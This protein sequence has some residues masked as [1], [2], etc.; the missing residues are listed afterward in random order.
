MKTSIKNLFA[1]VLGLVV[2]SSSAFA[3]ESGKNN[4]NNN[5]KEKSFTILNEVK[6]INK[7]VASGNVEVFV[8]QAPAES[9]KVYDSYYSKN[10][11][12][13]QKDGVL[14]I[15][16]FEK[17]PLSVTVY[18]RNLTA[19]EAGDNATV[20]TFGKVS[21][22]T[23]D[24]VLKDKASADINAKTISLNTSV[25][26]NASLKLSGSTEEHF[27]LMGTS[28]KMSTGQF[29]A[30]ISDIKSIAPKYVAQAKVVAP[31]LE[32]IAD[33]ELAK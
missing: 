32:S 10:A 4:N 25:T 5:T 21:F 33:I 30:S 24:V 26:D 11:L 29:M 17:E 12:V 20:K 8:V 15:S 6:N 19:I 3:T 2:M 18:V 13:Q 9:V 23:L 1:A 16:S 7:I 14:R 28:A 22:L 27:A 31:T